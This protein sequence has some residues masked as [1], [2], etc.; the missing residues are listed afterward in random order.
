PPAVQ[1]ELYRVTQEALNN[2]AKY[3]A[4]DRIVVHLHSSPRRV[5][6]RI[7]DNGRGF[8]V[9]GVPAGHLGI[10]FMQERALSVGAV[11]RIKSRAGV[12]TQVMVIWAAD[13]Q[14]SSGAD[15]SASSTTCLPTAQRSAADSSRRR[16]STR[17]TL[18]QLTGA[19]Q[20]PSLP[21]MGQND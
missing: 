5:A 17:R 10:K 16:R 7:H 19:S 3:A 8:D 6:L 12:G 9:S 1:I 20:L 11:C 2:V 18:T 15:G 4:A 21:D 14:A 13:N